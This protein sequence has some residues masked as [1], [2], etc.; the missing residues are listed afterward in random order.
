MRA[1]NLHR[2]VRPLWLAA[3]ACLWLAGGQP[4]TG[5]DVE[6]G[7]YELKAAFLFNF[8]KFTDWPVGTFVSADSPIVIGI[9]GDCNPFGATLDNLVRGE[10]VQD[11]RLVIKRLRP[12]R[13]L[14]SCRLLFICRSETDPGA[15]RAQRP[16]SRAARC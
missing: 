3:L 2:L 16:G 15:G 6:A 8:S 10:L 4:A 11:R 13:N 12:D 9:V 14:W 7:E 1:T 5:H